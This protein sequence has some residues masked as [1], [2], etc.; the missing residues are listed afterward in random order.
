MAR[1]GDPLEQQGAMPRCE[2]AN[3]AGSQFFVCLEYK[4]HLDR[5]YT[6]FG[7]VVNGLDTVKKL[8]AVPLADIRNGRPEKPPVIQS[9]KV[10]PV[11][12]DKN[13]Y[14]SMLTNLPK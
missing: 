8:G 2:F 12:A 11:T 1:S 6:A 4:E 3:S 10:E 13:P 9:V 5:K 14:A 7:R